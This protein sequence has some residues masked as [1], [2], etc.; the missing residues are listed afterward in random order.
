MKIMAHF[1]QIKHFY[2]T[3]SYPLS[4]GSKLTVDVAH[5]L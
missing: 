5:I 2:G 3:A 1:I 4:H